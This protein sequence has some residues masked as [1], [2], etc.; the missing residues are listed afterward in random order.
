[1]KGPNAEGIEKL[2]TFCS[3]ALDKEA[4]EKGMEALQTM[5]MGLEPSSEG[6]GFLRREAAKY[7]KQCPEAV[8]A[9]Q[10]L[11]Y[12][13][14]LQQAGK[15]AQDLADYDIPR[16]WPT[17]MEIRNL[18]PYDKFKTQEVFNKVRDKCKAFL[19]KSRIHPWMKLW[20]VHS[21]DKSELFQKVEIAL[22]MCPNNAEEFAALEAIH[23]GNRIDTTKLLSL[24]EIVDK[25]I[26][27]FL[28]FVPTVREIR[29]FYREM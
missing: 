18:W 25:V 21:G 28:V 14:T 8:E 23:A 1:M 24:V 22:C 4:G 27:Y 2:G 5:L 13:Y 7:S 11:E 12:M 19:G 17:A 6:K 15:S 26:S 3:A 29:D 16:E 9:L 10:T 20:A